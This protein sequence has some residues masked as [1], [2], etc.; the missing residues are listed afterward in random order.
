MA[1]GRP[2]GSAL[3]RRPGPGRPRSH[4]VRSAPQRAAGRTSRSARGARREGS[5]RAFRWATLPLRT[6]LPAVRPRARGRPA[7][8]GPPRHGGPRLAARPGGRGLWWV[9]RGRD[10]HG[11][12]PSRRHTSRRGP[13]RS[14]FLFGRT[15]PVRGARSPLRATR[16]LPG[17]GW[18]TRVRCAPRSPEGDIGAGRPVGPEVPAGRPEVPLPGGRAAGRAPTSEGGAPGSCGRTWPRGGGP[19]RD[20][21]SVAGHTTRCGREVAAGPR[22]ARSR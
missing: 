11:R 16:L 6:G 5:P 1:P 13:P 14:R 9:R 12:T 10:G 18:L 17:D 15:R 2:A 20:G 7:R 8:A 21:P 22:W 3:R 4:G 19:S